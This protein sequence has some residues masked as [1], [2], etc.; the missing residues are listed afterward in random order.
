MLLV[1]APLGVM[2]G[3]PRYV[4]APVASVTNSSDTVPNTFFF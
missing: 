3:T 2:K 4:G 1:T